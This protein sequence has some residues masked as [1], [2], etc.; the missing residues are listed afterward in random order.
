MLYNGGL[1]EKE[2]FMPRNTGKILRPIA[3]IM[4]SSAIILETKPNQ[5]ETPAEPTASLG[6]YIQNIY[7]EHK[8]TELDLARHVIVT[9]YHHMELTTSDN[10]LQDP[11]TPPTPEPTPKPLPVQTPRP[12]PQ[13]R[14]ATIPPIAR[15]PV[16]ASGTGDVWDLLVQ[17]ETQGDW[18]ANTGNGYYGGLQFDE[19][20]WRSVGGRG[21]PANAPIA[22][23]KLRA[24]LLRQQRGFQPW[25]AC[26]AQL[27]LR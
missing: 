6:K 27:G 12:T 17:C 5:P 2:R 7:E 21:N 24:E 10:E 11:Q 1:M 16:R 14:A 3:A 9:A 19:Q 4:M 13:A 26:S 23:Q 25:P 20:T 15:Q 22:E 18:Y 8:S